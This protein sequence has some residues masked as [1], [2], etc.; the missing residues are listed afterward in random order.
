[1]SRTTD[2]CYLGDGVYAAMDLGMIR[3]RTEGNVIYLEPEV[4]A[5]LVAYADSQRGN[6]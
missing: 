6:G 4:Y 3:L 1:M 5:A 2:E